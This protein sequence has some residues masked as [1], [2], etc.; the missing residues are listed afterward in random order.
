MIRWHLADNIE[1]EYVD[2]LGLWLD[3]QLSGIIAWQLDDDEPAYI[4]SSV[5]AVRYGARRQGIAL[6][7]KNELLEIAVDAG[8]A[9]I[10]ST[11][12]WDNDPMRA[13]NE[14]LGANVYP[15]AGDND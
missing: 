3:D 7:L 14:Q 8:V 6:Q 1:R 4:R 5:L 11:V 10:V 2:G 15:I 9:A 12:H 13:L